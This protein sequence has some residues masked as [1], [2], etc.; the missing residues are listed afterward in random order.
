MRVMVLSEGEQ[1]QHSSDHTSNPCSD[2]QC[3]FCLCS[4]L[5]FLNVMSYDFHG[6]WET[7]TG[8]HSPL[9]RSAIDSGTHLDYNIVRNQATCPN[10]AALF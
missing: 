5:D 9:Y 1:N 7:R 4:H 10:C 3:C 2:P 6:H 8:H